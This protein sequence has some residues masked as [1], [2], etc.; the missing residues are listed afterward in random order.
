[1]QLTV[2][3][4]LRFAEAFQQHEQAP[5]VLGKAADDLYEMEDFER[6]IS[7]AEI[8]IDRYPATESSLIR[9]A[10]AVI[11]H[12]SMDLAEYANAEF[13]YVSV[14]AIDVC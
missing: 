14:L 11:A 10:W 4:S 1:M 6:A 8:L 5:V 12:S 7:A 3:S 9:S 13:A 2:A